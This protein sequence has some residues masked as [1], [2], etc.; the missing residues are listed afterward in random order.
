MITNLIIFL[1]GSVFTIIMF[2]LGIYFGYLIGNRT[3]DKK[4]AKVK[5]II[6]KKPSQSGPVKMKSKSQQL[7]EQDAE[8]KRIRELAGGE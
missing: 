7:I 3:I 2:G 1:A 8:R 5:N 6:T 4:L